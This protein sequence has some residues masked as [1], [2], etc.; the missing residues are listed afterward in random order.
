MKKQ[1]NGFE[2]ANTK[3]LNEQIEDVKASKLTRTEKMIALKSFGL[4]DREITL[5]LNSDLPKGLFNKRF[6]YTFGVEIECFNANTHDLI[7]AGTENNIEIHSEGYNHTDNKKYFKLVPDGS[8][9]GN[10]PNEMV[11]PVLSG[12]KGIKAVEN[13]CKALNSV[14][15]RVNK[16]CGLHVHIG[17]EKL[18]GEQYVNVFKNYQKLEKVI[19]TFMAES[20]R[21]DNGFYCRSLNQIDF[22]DYHSVQDVIYRV[23]CCRYYK[24]NAL[25]YSRH[26]T[27][28]FRQHQGTTNFKKISN[29][30]KFCAKL[31]NY[32]R[33]N[34]LEDEVASVNDIPFLNKAEK[35][36][37]S[38]RVNEFNEQG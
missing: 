25:S 3:S 34:V 8:I 23:G 38:A 22:S 32:S 13:A 16:S 37:F 33:F 11:S 30:I 26:K 12:S 31:V 18:T 1:Q 19:D 28:E 36:F 2:F 6:A 14:G 5:I 17:A 21:A 20:R 10:E 4:L 29:W 7:N 27:I 35:R 24:V 9:S 15:A